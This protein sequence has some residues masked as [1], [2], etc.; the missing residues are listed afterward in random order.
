[1]CADAGLTVDA[2]AKALHVTARTVRNW[3]SGRVQVPYSA[4]RLVRILGRFELPDP[5]WKGWLMHSGKLWSPE[6]HGFNPSDS[7]WWGLLVRQA[8]MFRQI[9][10]RQSLF[11]VLMLR[12]G[13]AALASAGDAP[14]SPAGAA[15]RA[16]DGEAGRAAQPPGPNLL[17][18]D[19]RTQEGSRP[20]STEEKRPEITVGADPTMRKNEGDGHAA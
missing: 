11:D 14:A 10:D 12:A 7:N 16:P 8:A 13:R 9:Y 3:F 15:R 20:F 19:F 17:P 1:M 2:V 5:A 4:Y 6:G 18:S